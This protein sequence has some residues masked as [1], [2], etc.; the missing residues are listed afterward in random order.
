MTDNIETEDTAYTNSVSIT[1]TTTEPTVE[2]GA[3]TINLG[4]F[5]SWSLA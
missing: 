4:T 5:L 1:N 3:S 2:A